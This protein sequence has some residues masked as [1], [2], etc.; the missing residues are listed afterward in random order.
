VI[1]IYLRLGPSLRWG[2]TVATVVVANGYIFNTNCQH[3]L[4]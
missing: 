2:D 4:I 3:A 1:V